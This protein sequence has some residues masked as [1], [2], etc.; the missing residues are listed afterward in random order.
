MA[1]QHQRKNLSG[2]SVLVDSEFPEIILGYYT[3]AIRGRI[4]WDGVSEDM[5]KGLPKVVP[6]LTLARLAVSQQ[7]QGQRHGE[8]LLVDAMKSVKR[9][10]QKIGGSFLFVDAK[11]TELAK[12]YS[13]YGFVALSSDPSILC[14]KITD[15]P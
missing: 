12:F 8:R 13:R 9:I 2:T 4:L 3:L 10:A 15:I 7:F 6:A 5:Q 1:R 14:M 11:N